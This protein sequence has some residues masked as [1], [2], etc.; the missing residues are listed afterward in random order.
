MKREDSKDKLSLSALG[1][2]GGLDD[3]PD[4][5]P[6]TTAPTSPISSDSESRPSISKC[7]DNVSPETSTIQDREGDRSFY[8]YSSVSIRKKK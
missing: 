3:T 1:T 2:V 8:E 6:V 5:T 7:T 4:Q